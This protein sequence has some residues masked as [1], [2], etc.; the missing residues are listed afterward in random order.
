M[1]TTLTS[2]SFEVLKT[3]L[4]YRPTRADAGGIA[5][6]VTLMGKQ[7]FDKVEEKLGGEERRKTEREAVEVLRSVCASQSVGGGDWIGYVRLRGKA[8]KV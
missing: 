1:S 2:T 6:W 4:E 5:G 8:R 7:F 3:E